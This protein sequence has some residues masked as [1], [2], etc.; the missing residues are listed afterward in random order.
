MRRLAQEVGIGTMTLYGHFRDKEELLDAVVDRAA[1]RLE[2]PPRGG[3]WRSQ[4]H[5]LMEGIWRALAEHPFG[6]FL[7]QRRPMWSPGALRVAEAGVG[8]L[9]DAGLSKADAARGYRSLFNYTFGFAAFSPTEVV[10]AHKE[11]ALA[12]LASLPKD[13]YPAQTEVA[14]ELAD[15]IGG[16]AQF[17]YGL[18]LILDGLE[19]KLNQEA[20]VEA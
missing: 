13:Q 19:L 20:A 18:D 5:S 12:A 4:I 15:G 16:V 9:R 8:A 7:R 10:P 14:S 11:A 17:H 3:P 2:L 1:E 6:V